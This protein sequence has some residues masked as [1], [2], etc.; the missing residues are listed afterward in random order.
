MLGYTRRAT[1]ELMPL[2]SEL[3]EFGAE[4]RRFIQCS[5][6]DRHDFRRVMRC[7]KQQAAAI[8]T[9]MSRGRHSA[10]AGFRIAP[11]FAFERECRRAHYDDRQTC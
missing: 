10:A 2:R 11:G 1:V 5:G 4:S 8:R 7:A 3:D 6:I 9:E